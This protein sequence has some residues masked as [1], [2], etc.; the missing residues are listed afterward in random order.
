MKKS[1]WEL[2]I[3]I[4]EDWPPQS[5]ILKVITQKPTAAIFRVGVKYLDKRFVLVFC[6]DQKTLDY[7]QIREWTKPVFLIKRIQLMMKPYRDQVSE[8]MR[9]PKHFEKGWTVQKY[10]DS[11]K[12]KWA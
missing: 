10:I 9:D 3:K 12:L 7:Y 11:I 2:D 1:Y 8:F 5:R 6:M 4:G